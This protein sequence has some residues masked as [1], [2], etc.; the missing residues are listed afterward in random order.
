ML[1]M[2]TPTSNNSIYP[3]RSSILNALAPDGKCVQLQAVIGERLGDTI[4][5]FCGATLISK[6]FIL[7]AAHCVQGERLELS[8][9]LPLS[10]YL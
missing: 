5:W 4:D 9:T 8:L 1:C 6:N 2:M 7:T 3:S 10:L